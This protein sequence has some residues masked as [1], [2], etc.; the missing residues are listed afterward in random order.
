MIYLF[1]KDISTFLFQ[2]RL[3][4]LSE[5]L[6]YVTMLHTESVNIQEKTHYSCYQNI[7]CPV[8]GS[9]NSFI[10]IKKILYSIFCLSHWDWHETN[11]LKNNFKILWYRIWKVSSVCV[12]TLCFMYCII[13]YPSGLPLP[14][15]ISIHVVKMQDKKETTILFYVSGLFHVTFLMYGRYTLTNILSFFLTLK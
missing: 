7:S 4:K 14:I 2:K 11:I 3:K 5:F 6:L 1:P 8:H 9:S 13:E 12:L 15:T 10:Y